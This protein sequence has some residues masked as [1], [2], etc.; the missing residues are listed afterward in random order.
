MNFRLNFLVK[1]TLDFPGSSTNRI[2]AWAVYLI[3][4]FSTFFQ[5]AMGMAA[6]LK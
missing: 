3:V 1:K 5:K 2:Y 6:T 4:V